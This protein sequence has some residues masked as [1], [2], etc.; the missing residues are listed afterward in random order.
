M[1]PISE[2]TYAKGGDGLKGMAVN[3]PETVDGHSF[4]LWQK[5]FLDNLIKS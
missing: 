1:S 2:P 5:R 3:V 4:R